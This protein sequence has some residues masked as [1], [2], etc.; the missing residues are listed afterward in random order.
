MN[1]AKANI[2][3]KLKMQLPAATDAALPAEPAAAPEVRSPAQNVEQFVRLLTDNHAEVMRIKRA[4]IA[5]SVKTL[6]QQRDINQLMCGS[7]WVDALQEI[8]GEIS[9]NTFYPSIDG[10]KDTL[11]NSVPAAITGSRC[12]IAA[13]GSIVLW[14]D[15]SEPRSLSLVPPLHI[16]VVEQSA[17][18][19]D[20]GELI[21]KQ[22]WSEQLPT[23]AVL[24][25]GPSKTA[26]IQQTLAYGAHGPRELVVLLVE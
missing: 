3:A 21:R 22:R 26:D 24:I 15:A 2:L 7:G 14:P 13:T 8:E 4:E 10:N 23:N 18:Y 25:S 9:L 6:L 17:I 19:N 20:F 12:A 1:S 11:F 5:A 16:V